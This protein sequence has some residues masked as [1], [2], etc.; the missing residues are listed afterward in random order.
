MQHAAHPPANS[1][2]PQH[3]TR[4]GGSHRGFL[5]RWF[6][7]NSLI[8]GVLALC[9]LLLR[10]GSKP[11]RLAYPCQQAAFSAATLAFGV[12]LVAALIAARQRVVGAVRTPAGVVLAAVGVLATLGTWGY[13]SRANEYQGPRLQPSGDY[14]AQLYHVSDCPPFPVG[15]RFVGLDNLLTLMGR[16]GLKIYKSADESLLSGPDGIVAADDVVIIKINYQW[17]ERGGSNVDVLR[18]LIRRI[19][20]HPDIFSGEIVVCENAQFQSIDNFDR[21]HNNAQI[22]S[23]SPHDVVVAFEDQGHQISHYDWTSVR[24]TSVAEYDDGDLT[25]GYIVYPYDSQFYGRLS[26]PKFQT[27]YGT[28]ISTKDGIWDP[29]SGAYDRESLKFINL[30]VLKS[31][32]ATYG[33]T[34]C[35]KNYMGVVTRELSTNSHGAIEY[36]ILGA[37]LAEMQ[38]ADLN[39]LDCIWVHANPYDGP[40]T[41]YEEATRRDELVASTDPVAADIWATS[42]ILIPAFLDNGYTPPWPT[43]SADPDD[44]DSAFRVYL[45]NSMSH[46]LA[47]GYEVTNDQD[48]IDAVTWDGTGDHDR[49]SDVDLTDYN[50]FNGCMSGPSQATGFTPPPMPCQ[51]AFDFDAD[52]DVDLVDFAAMGG[53]FTGPQ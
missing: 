16:E 51:D 4:H 31:H 39:I 33:V 50:I 29:D 18:G 6:L 47:A 2:R 32:H 35:V 19:V 27:S 11:S 1:Q 8:S 52:S 36:G 49:D 14:R 17:P 12:P 10:S 46:L 53:V 7:A 30:P 23:L 9:W 22:H 43:P 20:D 38:P 28:Y 24:F 25:D 26:Y 5:K 37:L 40:W 15:D 34:A 45:D 21:A 42:N 41:E 13:L 44:P 3:H 48:Q